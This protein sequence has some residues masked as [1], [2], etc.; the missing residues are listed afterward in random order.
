MFLI[1]NNF[2]LS[3]RTSVAISVVV[4]LFLISFTALSGYQAYFYTLICFVLLDFLC[5]KESRMKNMLYFHF[6]LIVAVIMYLV[7]RDQFPAYMGLSGPPGIGT[8]DVNYFGGLDVRIKYILERP[9]IAMENS[10]TPLISRLYLLKVFDP[11]DVIIFNLLGISFIPY[12]TKK[13]AYIFLQDKPIAELSE[14]LILTCPFMMSVG[15]IIMRDVICTSLILTSFICFVK[16][17]FVLFIILLGMLSYLKFGFVVFL[18]VVI[19][20]YWVM[21]ENLC[22]RNR[23]LFFIKFLIVVCVLGAVFVLFVLPNLS[24]ITGDRLSP[25]SL[26]RESFIEYLQAANEDSFLVKV[27][28]LPIVIRIPALIVSFLVMPP[29]APVFMVDGRFVIGIFMNSILA[30]LY[31][32]CLYKYFFNFMLSYRKLTIRAKGVMYTTLFLSLSLGMIS[33]QYRHKVVLMPFIYMI[34]AYAMKTKNCRNPFL[35]LICISLFVFMNLLYFSL[36]L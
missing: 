25:E 31:W 27:Y 12:L 10:Y 18:G 17:R 4:S 23:A 11:I 26:F 2:R 33:L 14:K 6:F 20:C 19:S 8:D 3:P 7:Q 13:V 22:L 1:I 34:I 28:D 35:S 30:P 16:R 36:H 32:C 24:V 21:K 29:L 15:L 9:D 5:E